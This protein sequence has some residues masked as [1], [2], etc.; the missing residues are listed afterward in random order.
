LRA[1]EPLESASRQPRENFPNSS[2]V[3]RGHIHSSTPGGWD[4]QEREGSGKAAASQQRG[5]RAFSEAEL[6]AIA[7]QSLS[8]YPEERALAASRFDAVAPLFARSDLVFLAICEY[9]AERRP[10]SA[11]YHARGI[12]ERVIRDRYGAIADRLGR[13]RV[14]ELRKHAGL[15]HCGQAIK[16]LL[17]GV[18][19]TNPNSTISGI[20]HRAARRDTTV[21]P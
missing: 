3:S 6:L 12:T 10:A 5:R 7:W 17:E 21:D 9:A 1:R 20:P 15:Q 4:G 16:R 19:P 18:S 14:A 8:A 2:L 13:G 11:P